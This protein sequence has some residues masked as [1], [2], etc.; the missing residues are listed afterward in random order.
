MKNWLLRIFLC[1]TLILSVAGGPAGLAYASETVNIIKVGTDYGAGKVFIPQIRGMED[2]QTQTMLNAKI[3]ETFFSFANAA[4]DSSLNGDFSVSFYNQ[5]ILGLHFK[6]DSFTRGSA[7]PNKIDRGIHLDLAT[8][9]IFKL[10]DLF[11]AGVDFESRIKE[12]CAA[13]PERY[14][15]RMEGIWDGWKM[16]EFMQSWQ[17][18]DAEFLASATAV[19]VYS[20]PRFATGAI[21]GYSLPYAELMDS[22]D[23]KG[24]FWRKIQDKPTVDISVVAF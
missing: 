3:K 2:E 23:P 19:R 24:V 14:R 6:G 21:G 17:G 9:Q 13:N 18:A 16:E 5:N 10:S 15:L 11:I 7:H 1:M 4:P 8:G 22:I 12:R 20:I